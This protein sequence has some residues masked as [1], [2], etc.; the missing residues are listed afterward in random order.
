MPIF[1]VPP[2]R[3]KRYGRLFETDDEEV[4]TT[5][6]DLTGT[7][8]N[9][10]KK[11]IINAEEARR[12]E[13]TRLHMTAVVDPSSERMPSHLLL[14]RLTGILTDDR[15]SIPVQVTNQDNTECGNGSQSMMLVDQVKVGILYQSCSLKY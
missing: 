8:T 6:N 1:P 14:R 4:G 2:N 7:E 13:R 15:Y 12:R 9:A 5:D 10:L 11:N 3:T